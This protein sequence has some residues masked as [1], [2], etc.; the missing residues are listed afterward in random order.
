MRWAVVY[1]AHINRQAN[2][3]LSLLGLVPTDFPVE[4]LEISRHIQPRRCAQALPA[5]CRIPL[6]Q[7]G[8]VHYLDGFLG[9]TVW[10]LAAP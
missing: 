2:G 10:T 8:D 1:P 9:S 5:D 4:A 3:L 6:I 7:N